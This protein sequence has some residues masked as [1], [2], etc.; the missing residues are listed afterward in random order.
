MSNKVPQIWWYVN[1]QPLLTFCNLPLSSTMRVK[2]LRVNHFRLTFRKAS[3]FFRYADQTLDWDMIFR[4][5][6]HKASA[7]FR[8]ADKMQK[9]KKH[10]IARVIFIARVILN[11][12]E[13]GPENWQFGKLH[14]VASKPGRRKHRQIKLHH[15]PAMPATMPGDP[16]SVNHSWAIQFL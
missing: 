5:S 9:H 2:H 15:I 8:N 12:K 1:L 16:R 13:N 10:G 4:A 3:A 11:P 14:S 7:S 6:F